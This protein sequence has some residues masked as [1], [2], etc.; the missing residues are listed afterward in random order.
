MG[1]RTCTCTMHMHMHV[2][3]HMHMH[4]RYAY[5]CGEEPHR[6]PGVMKRRL[7]LLPHQDAPL[8]LK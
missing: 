4:V 2:H 7:I 6:L 3:M 1:T 5:L 8:V